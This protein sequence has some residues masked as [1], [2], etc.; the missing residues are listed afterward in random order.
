MDL[1][2]ITIIGA[3]PTGLY[4]AYYAGF[5]A[6]RT[7]IVDSQSDLGGQVTALYPDKYIYDVA[8]FPK[9][10][11]KDLIRNQVEQAM[12]YEP[13]VVLNERVERLER[14][15]DGNYRL[16][17][18][19]GQE[20]FTRVV[21]ITAGIGAFT[22]KKY[23]RPELDRY[24]GKGL[25]FAVRNREDFR[26][27]RVLVVGGGDS[28]LDWALNLLPLVRELTLIHR[29]D[30]FR[31]HEDSVRKL[32]ASP[33]KVKL[34]YELKALEGADRVERAL[35]FNNRTKEE[36]VLE[37]D[38]VLAFLGLV[39]NL[40]P[41]R[42]WGLVI[43]EDSIVVNTKMETNLPGVY[44]AGDITTYPGKLKLIATGYG[45]AATAVNNA[46]TYL[47]PGAKAFPGHSST[48]MEKKEREA[49][50]TG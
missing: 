32:L 2:D 6:L 45:E 46:Y 18:H 8:G 12:Q 29:R 16:V 24:E 47:N 5:R 34:F 14:L 1:Y 35:I 39:S 37:V 7:K 31:A 17:T 50:R 28:A 40:G 10:L 26:D 49:A 38:A 27:R 21:L 4:A 44:A 48:I 3:G 41:I 20:H 11:G 42:E 9:I 23:N 22:P 25:H 13:T 36:E 30:Q 15:A 43:E 19:T 33:A